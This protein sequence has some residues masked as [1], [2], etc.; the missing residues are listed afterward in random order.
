LPAKAWRLKLLP[1]FCPAGGADLVATE[2]DVS[3]KEDTFVRDFRNSPDQIEEWFDQIE[4]S[5]ADFY[6]TKIAEP[7]HPNELFDAEDKLLASDV[8]REEDVEGDMITTRDVC[9]PGSCKVAFSRAMRQRSLHR[10]IKGC[11]AIELGRTYLSAASRT[12]HS[13]RSDRLS[14]AV[15]MG[16]NAIP[17]TTPHRRRRPRKHEIEQALLHIKGLVYARNPRRR[18]WQPSRGRRALG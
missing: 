17:A 15:N 7:T 12:N 2:P 11:R 5:F 10:E 3:G 1:N 9:A 16:S 18:R 6:E 13:Y 4:E 8:I 14:R